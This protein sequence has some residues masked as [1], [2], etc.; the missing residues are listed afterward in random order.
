[1]VHT[2]GYRKTNKHT[3]THV[4]ENNFRKPGMQFVK[5]KEARQSLHY[6]VFTD[7]NTMFY[8]WA[9]ANLF[10]CIGL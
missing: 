6:K 7:T 1:M 10:E 8:W 9:N 2:H 3:C 5:T 4:S